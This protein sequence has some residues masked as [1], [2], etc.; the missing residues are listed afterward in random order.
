MDLV[1]EFLQFHGLESTLSV[2]LAETGQGQKACDRKALASELKQ[3]S[4][5]TQTSLL[6][7]LLPAGQT[8]TPQPLTS[9]P[10]TSSTSIATSSAL[11][12]F[13][14][15]APVASVTRPSTT[16]A[17]GIVPLK[18]LSTL[19]PASEST[20]GPLARLPVAQLPRKPSFASQPDPNTSI[21][22]SESEDGGTLNLIDKKMNQLKKTTQAQ[23]S[24]EE[25]EAEE[26]EEEEVEEDYEDDFDAMRYAKGPCI[27]PLLL[28]LAFLCSDDS[29]VHL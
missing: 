16:P 17:Q 20:L 29:L 28:T 23:E 1:S 3:I 26:E 2:L 12:P 4:S 22:D 27:S 5:N 6:Q 19:L 24:D 25:V 11:P 14:S 15:T 18:P 21:E 7:A 10:S 8:H 13:V 9:K